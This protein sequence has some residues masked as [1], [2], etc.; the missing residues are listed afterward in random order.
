MKPRVSNQ[1]TAALT[2]FEVLLVI[3]LLM[4]LA[5]IFVPKVPERQ[6]ARRSMCLNNLKQI[7]VAN[8]VWAGNH[9]G[10]FPM[11]VSVTNWGA[12]ELALTGDV[13][14]IFCTLS[15]ELATPK[16]LW[17]PS[18]K[19]RV[20][21]KDFTTGLSAKNVS[22]FVGLDADTKHPQMFLSGD[23]N[24]ASGGV[25]VKSGLLEFS[26]NAFIAFTAERHGNGGN[27]GLAD[28]SVRAA[29]LGYSLQQMLVETGLATNR[30][31]IP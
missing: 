22:Y 29:G 27:I 8:L 28:G 15:N 20:A 25:P 6:P 21:A 3:V 17:C 24:F 31:A 19:D 5:A 12:R 9:N 18:D 10:K 14:G 30:L 23:D 13:A 26:T 16:I 7:A 4:I 11:Q 1:K 2:L